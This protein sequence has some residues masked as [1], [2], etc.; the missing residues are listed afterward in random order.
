MF[1]VMSFARLIQNVMAYDPNC[2]TPEQALELAT[3]KAAQVLGLEKEIGSIEV[4]K[5][6]DFILVD[7]YHPAVQPIIDLPQALVHS[8]RGHYVTDVFVNAKRVVSNS[9]LVGLDEK[10]LARDALK[11]SN[12]LL[13]A[14]GLNG[15]RI[16]WQQH[17]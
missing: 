17:E 16:N 10:E 15:L 3:I 6:A 8:V 13:S 1:E 2:I 9:K 7:P 5:K 11:Y 4:G 12:K 14:A